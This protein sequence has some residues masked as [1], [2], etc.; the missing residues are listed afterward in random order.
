M[1]VKDIDYRAAMLGAWARDS[2]T[3]HRDDERDD[4]EALPDK[5]TKEAFLD[6]LESFSIT[7]FPCELELIAD[8]HTARQKVNIQQLLSDA[9]AEDRDA[10][11]KLR[12]A[13]G[14]EVRKGYREMIERG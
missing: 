4:K 13:T 1:R 11:K 3:S 7:M 14:K 12:G 10:K 9:E 5:V 8:K 6:L 2:R